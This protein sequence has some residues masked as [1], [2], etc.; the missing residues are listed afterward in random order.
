MKKSDICYSHTCKSTEMPSLL[1]R[2]FKKLAGILLI[3][4]SY[5]TTKWNF[6][7][8]WI[9]ELKRGTKGCMA[10]NVTKTLL[11]N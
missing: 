5:I 4:T 1:L 6:K 9:N 7:N 2:L 11:M 10:I 3:D 8:K